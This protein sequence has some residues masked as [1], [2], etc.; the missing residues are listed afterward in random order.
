VEYTGPPVNI[1]QGKANDFTVPQSV[2]SHQKEHRIVAH[3]ARRTPINSV[4][5]GVDRFPRDSVR[6]LLKPVDPWGI[7]HRVERASENTLFMLKPEKG[8]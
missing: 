2:G 5:Q 3:A 1:I 7:N 6:D 4:K 8:P